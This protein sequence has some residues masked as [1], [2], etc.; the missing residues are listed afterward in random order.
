MRYHVFP[1]LSI[2]EHYGSEPYA[3][4][5]KV[6]PF[7]R[8][9]ISTGKHSESPT[10]ATS[11]QAMIDPKYPLEL[12]KKSHHRKQRNQQDRERI[13]STKNLNP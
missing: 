3:Q 4:G 8:R 11:T 9:G 13:A 5:A 10:T 6:W 12:L 2:L 1:L 7:T